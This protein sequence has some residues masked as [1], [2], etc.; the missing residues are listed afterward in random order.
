MDISMAWRS[1]SIALVLAVA[2]S[3]TFHA[4][5]PAALAA[6]PAQASSRSGRAPAGREQDAIA[7]LI[8]KLEA[9]SGAGDR[10]ALM[11][12]GAPGPSIPG[13]EEFASYA[14]PAADRFIIKERDRTT[15]DPTTERLLLEVFIERGIEARIGTWRIDVLSSGT[16][17]PR[18]WHIADVERLTV[19]SGLY[20]LSLNP[21]KQFEV[22][23]LVM[24]G[25]DISL[26]LP[27][28]SAFIADTPE[29]TTA[30][31]LVGRGTMNFAPPDPAERTQVR[32]FS[33]ED[34]LTGEFDAA[35]VR[36]RP[37][38]FESR[39]P[40]ASLVPK[41][42]SQSDFRRAE[43][44][45]EEYV[46]RTLQIDLSD[47]S[48]HRWSLTPQ[49]GDLI[50]E[51][52]TRRFG[53]LTYARA[54]RDAEDISLFDR[55]RRRNIAVY[56]SRDK[57]ASRGR[58]YSE[59]DLVEYDALA[60]EIDVGF[61][62]DRLWVE[63]NA[64]IKI[65]V[66][67][68]ALSTLTL[69]LAETLT[70][71]GVYSPQFG[72]LLHL[73]VVGQNSVIVNLPAAIIRG[74]EM[75]L[76]VLYGGRLEPQALEREAITVDGEP[77]QDPI[78]PEQ[79]VIPLEPR[80]I[81]SNRSYWYP[82]AT[83]TDYA[84]ARLRIN[85]PP[86]FEVVAS[87]S[88]VGEPQPAAGPV[89]AGQRPRK[90]Y[91]FMS[92]RPVRYLSCVISRL[93]HVSRAQ[94]KVPSA[95]IAVAGSREQ[96]SGNPA[97]PGASPFDMLK[98]TLNQREGSTP[99]ATPGPSGSTE[100]TISLSIQANPRQVGRARG[101]VDRTGEILEYYSSLVGDAPYPSFTLA[102]TESDLPGG[103]S[104]A[105]FAVLNQPL[106]TSPFVWR[107]DPVSFENYPH[108]FLAHELAHQWWGQAVGWKNY[109]EQWISEGFAQ[110]FAALYAAHDRGA[111]T[112]D[113]I[114][115]QM[116]RWAVE[117][118]D[119]G[120]VYL[121]YRLGHV[122]GESRVFRA[123]VYNKGAAI[124]HML[125]RLMGDEAFFSGLKSFYREWRYQKAGTDD[126]RKAMET[127]GGRTLEPFFEGWIH[128]STIPRLTFTT[129][130]SATHA[131][132]KFEHSGEIVPVPVTVTVTYVDG[133]T[134]DTI[135]PVTER[136]VE[137]TI[138][139]TGGV[140]SI[141]ANR[142]N[143]ALAHIDR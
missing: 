70:V 98:K 43:E 29:G 99:A 105:Y 45:F 62:P 35:F 34:T 37:G 118:S 123:L 26:E 85:V 33:G 124:L 141:E 57:L 24:Q 113:S 130:L 82:Q 111:E 48:P 17:E 134:H 135:V 49:M 20:R 7:A 108:F 2:A 71:R 104:P 143:A 126:F 89:P 117:Q 87:G 13:L 44:I 128:G 3:S 94:L 69:K 25:L 5:G 52:R 107:N 27:S 63:G 138:K 122:R 55:K 22:R 76:S 50:A 95:Q 30:V 119:Q 58:F 90:Q 96:T 46:G 65:R 11:G 133:T 38:E 97:P 68:I 91:V 9:A 64:R 51:V 140:R 127:A 78:S 86:E 42:V 115:R 92:D 125:R 101:L 103:H 77:A 59:D 15:V 75:W 136:A 139:L 60:Y 131:V 31:V 137:R 120:P 47:L 109:H 1:A 18:E 10:E 36:I 142:D 102:V 23:N 21:T 28:G 129:E 106:P 80:F 84:A 81:Y 88:P 12:L 4:P 121:G 67:S 100:S 6:D 83:V 74:T 112:F 79:M 61:S 73:R 72:R 19:I 41:S 53:S 132:V 110:Y 40:S 39:F 116:R 56:A 14:V 54:G 66:N 32:L 8:A 93:T 114:M 16:G